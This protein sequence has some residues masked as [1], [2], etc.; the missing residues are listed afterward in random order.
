MDAKPDAS[1][2]PLGAI[3]RSRI[4]KAHKALKTWRK[5][6]KDAYEAYWLDENH[7][8]LFPLFWANTQIQHSAV[9]SRAPT[10]EVRRRNTEAVGPMKPLSQ[11]LE[12]A[13]NYQFDIQ[14]CESAFHSAV[15]DFLVAACGLVRV[16][17][18]PQ[19]ALDPEGNPVGIVSQGL[20]LEHIP[21][22]RL[23]WE[24][25]KSW[26]AVDWVAVEHM[27]SKAEYQEQFPGKPLPESAVEGEGAGA[28]EGEQPNPEAA[29]Y[30]PLYRVW[31]VF[32]KKR[33]RIVVIADGEDQ[34]L[35]VRP[36]AL[37]LA[38]FY[39]FARPMLMNLKKDELI[40]KP[41]YVYIRPQLTYINRLTKRI[42][43]L[44]KAIRDVGYYDDSL[45]ELS[46]LEDAQDGQL[47]P[48]RGL[49]E[50]LAQVGGGASL[51]ALIAKMPI[52]QMSIVLGHLR[53]MREDAKSQ[54]YEITG[55]SDLVRGVTDPNE[56]ATAQREKSQWAGARFGIKEREVIRFVRD[57]V[58]IMGE[59]IAEHFEPQILTQMTGME[60]TPEMVQIMRND[61]ARAFSVDIETDSTILADEAAER[62]ARMELINAVSN[63]LPSA[64]ETA[65]AQPATAPLMQQ[66]ML[67][68]VR[69]FKH[70]RQLEDEIEAMGQQMEPMQQMQ[71]QLADLQQ[72]LEQAQGEA[73]Q[74]QEQLGQVDQ[75]ENARKD[76]EAAVEAAEGQAKARKDH[77]E[78]ALKEQEA[79][80]RQVIPFNGL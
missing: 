72:Q 18:D 74:A 73:Q 63:F 39:P 76:Q 5:E 61:L 70:G 59:V 45:K 24:P 40:P 77:A 65:Q 62:E 16:N 6:A 57:T 3:W 60:F 79:Q 71:Q 56:T 35:E 41:E 25:N 21:Y 43:R 58:R 9:F 49:A 78:A 52:D 19:L 32:D 29:K 23:T 37:G 30:A 27:L 68:L 55:I 46:Q 8:E 47:I 26:K 1:K 2:K 51:N 69:S 11:G 34:P 10:A 14:D 64:L 53:E 7:R 36:D 13:I 67:F 12:R 4:Q 44:T 48:L 17:Y 54:V 15:D 38:G 22:A 50:R 80:A 66:L 42:D 33:R 31:E 20:S 75:A 28:G